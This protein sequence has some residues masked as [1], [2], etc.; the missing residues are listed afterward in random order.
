MK[1]RYVR[2]SDEDCGKLNLLED[3]GLYET[4]Y[5]VAIGVGQP[6]EYSPGG[7]ERIMALEPW[8]NFIYGIKD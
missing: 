1:Y 4:L 2:L 5:I 6:L 3:A 7:G 8:Y